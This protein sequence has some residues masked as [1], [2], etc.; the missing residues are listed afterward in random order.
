MR[1]ST[2]YLLVTAMALAVTSTAVA[3]QAAAGGSVCAPRALSKP[4]AQF[5]DH[6][7]YFL[8]DAADFETDGKGRGTHKS[9]NLPKKAKV[10]TDQ[11]P[12]KVNGADHRK[13]LEI[14][15]D[16][17]VTTPEVCVMVDE[18]FFRFFYKD[19]GKAGAA[20]S[21]VVTATSSIGTATNTWQ[22]GSADKGW[23]VSPPI[24]LPNVRGEN[25]EQQITI[26]FTT[27]K[28]REH[29]WLIDDLMIDPWRTR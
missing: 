26:S 7:D 20:L 22:V 3:G 19:P 24:A 29:K 16:T 15:D 4:F 11:S 13:A 1:R 14:G 17:T 18:E 21:V 27:S 2:T 25:G 10:A 5:G 9:W 28:G 12:W 23:K 6:N 8:V